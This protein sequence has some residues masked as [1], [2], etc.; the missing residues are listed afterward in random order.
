MCVTSHPVWAPGL[1]TIFSAYIVTY[2][3]LHS[4]LFPFPAGA[5]K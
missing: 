1:I 4:Q 3:G 5:L 2:A